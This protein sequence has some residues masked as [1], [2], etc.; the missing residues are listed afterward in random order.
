MRTEQPTATPRPPPV[1]ASS[2]TLT[3]IMSR[4][5]IS[6]T[7]AS[8]EALNTYVV[9]PAPKADTQSQKSLAKETPAMGRIDVIPPGSHDSN[10]PTSAPTTL[11]RK[12][13]EPFLPV[14]YPDSVSPDY[15]PYQ[16]KPFPIVA[17]YIPVIIG[18]GIP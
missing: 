13:L 4:I 8:G 6:E 9:S 16:S 12:L 2:G 7:T 14:G 15:T 10:R 5:I 11:A 3:T 17:L 18:F 1:S